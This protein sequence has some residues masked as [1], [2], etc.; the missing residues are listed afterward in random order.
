[1][2]KL[3][4]SER[5]EQ[6]ALRLREKAGDKLQIA[7]SWSDLAALSLAQKRYPRAKEFAERATA[8][9]LANSNAQAVDRVASRYTLSLALCYV[10]ACLSALPI[11]KRC[12]G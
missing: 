11:L 2:G 6:E 3:R 8:E 7:R 4:E 9:L 5:E 1:M 12:R 10:K